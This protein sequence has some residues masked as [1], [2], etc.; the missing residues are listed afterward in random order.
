M[1]ERDRC[2]R[3]SIDLE[4]VG[5]DRGGHLLVQHAL[6][7]LPLGGELEVRG[8]DPALRVHL[9]AWA[10]S[11]GHTFREDDVVVRGTARDAAAVGA[12]RAGAFPPSGVVARPGATWGVAARGALIEAGGPQ[13]HFDIEEKNL[14]WTDLAPRLYAQA[15]ASQWDPAAAV[16]WQADVELPPEVEAAVVQVMTY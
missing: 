1:T 2:V 9:R 11:Q 16:D 15:V 10:R 8:R 6:T 3:A 13:V 7:P 5:L 14:V 4:D 12:E